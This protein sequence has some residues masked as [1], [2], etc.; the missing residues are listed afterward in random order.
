MRMSVGMSLDIASDKIVQRIKARR[1]RRPQ[2][3]GYDVI[4]VLR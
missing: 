3:L 4:T 1:V 2:I